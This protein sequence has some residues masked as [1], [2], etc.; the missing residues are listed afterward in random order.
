MFLLDAGGPSDRTQRCN[1]REHLHTP[2]GM[3]RRWRRGRNTPTRFTFGCGLE[4]VIYRASVIYEKLAINT[5][6]TTVVVEILR[7][8]EE[9]KEASVVSRSRKYARK[10]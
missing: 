6:T 8:H 2:S 7:R 9:K 10:R 3:M 1:R 5:T 4:F